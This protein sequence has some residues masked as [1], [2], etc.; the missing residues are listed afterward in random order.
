M[1]CVR[2]QPRSWCERPAFL[3]RRSNRDQQQ[4]RQRNERAELHGILRRRRWPINFCVCVYETA[5][6]ENLIT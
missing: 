6:F 4:Q 3:C 1:V 5:N 2:V